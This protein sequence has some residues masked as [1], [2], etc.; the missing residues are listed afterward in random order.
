VAGASMGGSGAGM[1]AVRYP[2]RFAC[3]YSSVGVHIAS[4]S[5]Q[6]RSS[7]E[8]VCG[9]ASLD[10]PHESGLRTFEYLDNAFLL[11]RDPG[12][13]VP[14]IAFANGKNDGG[15]GWPQA[16]E[17]ARALQETRQPHLFTW[18]Q[19]GHGERVYV[20][21]PSGGGDGGPGLRGATDF[22]IDRSLPAFTR[23]S[24]DDDPG[25]GDPADGALKGQ[26]NLHLRWDPKD[27]VD[28][29][30]RWEATLYLVE[31]AP[32]DSCTA[33][34]TPRRLQKLKHRKGDAFLWS[35]TSLRD[36]REVQNG[37]GSVDAHGL[38]TLPAVEVTKGRNRLKLRRA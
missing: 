20:P 34:V 26:I 21:T 36:G 32:K 27:L 33:D 4:R 19:S 8:A 13:D 38:L 5:P 9:P 1:L 24:L 18:G 16:A 17:F 28:E 6:F 12:R 29:E 11:R 35:N 31:S 23:C 37:T 3:A 22:R 10:V 25:R 7:Y 15:I 14:F 30:D 2:D